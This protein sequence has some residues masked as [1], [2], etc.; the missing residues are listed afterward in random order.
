MR[1]EDKKVAVL[2]VDDHPLYRS[3][4]KALIEENFDVV[5]YEVATL[6]GAL[7]VLEQRTIHIVYLDLELPDGSGL[8]AAN[9][10]IQH[11]SNP[12]VYIL[13][14][15]RDAYYIH[16][17]REIGAHG[18]LFKD[19]DPDSIINSLSAAD[20]QRNFYLSD[21][22]RQSLEEQIETAENTDDYRLEIL[23]RREREVLYLLACDMTSKEIARHLGVSFRTI[24]NHRA[25]IKSKLLLERNSQLLKLSMQWK[26]KLERMFAQ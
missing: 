24:Q 14:T 8:S 12:V 1:A 13:T 19:D 9:N 17:A 26:P 21:Y 7:Q 2:L 16:H 22:V 23:T 6:K 10:F 25:N 15:H 20:T 11:K 5:V 4:T 3:G 18:Y